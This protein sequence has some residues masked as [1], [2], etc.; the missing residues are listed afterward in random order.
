MLGERG[1]KHATHARGHAGFL[2]GIKKEKIE[3]CFGRRET[4]RQLHVSI[5]PDLSQLRPVERLWCHFKNLRL[6]ICALDGKQNFR[7]FNQESLDNAAAAAELKPIGIFH[8]EL[9]EDIVI[10]LLCQSGHFHR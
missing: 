4:Q 5:N 7:L 9:R 2:A 6:P 10:V 3:L 1:V 8:V